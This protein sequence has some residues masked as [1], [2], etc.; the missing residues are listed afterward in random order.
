MKSPDNNVNEICDEFVKRSEVGY[1]KYG[2]TT[3]RNDLDFNAWIQHLKEELM[4]AIVYIH[5]V[6]KERYRDYIEQTSEEIN[7]EIWDDFIKKGNN[8][9]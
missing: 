3:E 5:R 8:G 1:K 7:E 2:V 4:D 9:Q 6:Q